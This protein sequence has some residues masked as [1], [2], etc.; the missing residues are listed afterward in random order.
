MRIR[1]GELRRLIR[2]AVGDGGDLATYVS[3]ESDGNVEKRVDAL[4]PYQGSHCVG[5]DVCANSDDVFSRRSV[6]ALFGLKRKD[7]KLAV[8]MT[9]PASVL[10]PTQDFLRRDVLKGYAHNAGEEPG[11]VVRFKG[12]YFAVDH[13]R[14]AA[15]ILKGAS[16]V[17]VRLIDYDGHEYQKPSERL[18]QDMRTDR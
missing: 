12:R 3:R 13:H 1:L 16:S 9:V 2:E 4:Q 6:N 7:L 15:Q 18:D 11:L 10:E 5:G 17:Q 14:I 8:K